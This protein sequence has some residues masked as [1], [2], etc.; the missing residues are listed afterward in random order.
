MKDHS[1]FADYYFFKWDE[2]VSRSNLILA[3]KLFAKLWRK[4]SSPDNLAIWLEMIALDK[5][6]IDTARYHQDN[7][8]KQA[9][10]TGVSTEHVAMLRKEIGNRRA[11]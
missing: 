11:L 6:E 4:N 2:S 10:K 8:L 9:L 5:V 3:R 7:V 1:S